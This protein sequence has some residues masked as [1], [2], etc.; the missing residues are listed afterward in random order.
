MVVLDTNTLILFFS[1]TSRSQA[2]LVKTLIESDQEITI[3]DVVFPETEYI[4]GKKYHRTRNDIHKVFQFFFERPNIHLN[5]YIGH[6]VDLYR[7][8]TLDMVDCLVIAQAEA[9]S[10][11][12]AT[13]DKKL[14][15]SSKTKAYWP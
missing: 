15:K 5:E 14:L 8:T 2:G 11:Q 4:L 6:A 7:K 3:P 9:K 13:F 1:Q 12:I 10:A